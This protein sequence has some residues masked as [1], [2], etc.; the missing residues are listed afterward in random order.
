M[1]I[2]L[3]ATAAFIALV[4]D[5]WST[6]YGIKLGARELDSAMGGKWRYAYSAFI[7]VMV[8]ILNQPVAWQAFGAV[9]LLA[10][11]WNTYQIVK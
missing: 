11:G 10:A 2:A 1:N 4:L 9:H 5:L 3:C 8:A 6:A 7:V